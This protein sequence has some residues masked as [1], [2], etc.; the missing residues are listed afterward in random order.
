M[1]PKEKAEELVSKYMWPQRR[2]DQFARLDVAKECALI[3]TNETIV[4][5]QVTGDVTWKY[6]IDVR[7]EL[8]AMK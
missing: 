8:E 2:F 7:N 6:W 1:T 4:A 3:A 5:L